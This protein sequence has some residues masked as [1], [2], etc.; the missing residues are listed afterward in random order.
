MDRAELAEAIA[1][2]N[3]P[4]LELVLVQLTGETR[5]LDPPYAPGRTRGLGDNPTGGLPE[6]V[7]QEVRDAAL[8]AI[9]A[10]LDGRPPAIPAPPHELLVRMLGVSMGEPVPDEYGALIAS[11]IEV[12]VGPD[13]V[14]HIDAPEDFEVLI[15]GAGLSGIAT[16]LRLREAGVAFTVVEKNPEVGGTWFE[17]RYPGA[18]VDTPSNLY[19]FSFAPYDW[20]YTFPPRDQLYAYLESLAVPI[21]DRLELETRVHSLTWDDHTKRWVAVTEHAG[22][23]LQRAFAVVVSAVGGLNRLRLPNIPGLDTFGGPVVHTAQWPD[24]LSVAGRRV[25]VIGNGASSMQVTPAV[26]TEVSE[27]TI[28]QRSPQWAAPFDQYQQPVPELLQRLTAAVPLY[29]IWM[30]LRGAWTFNDR[31]YEALHKDPEWPHPERAVSETN[32]GHRRYFTRYI[33]DKLA[34]RP[35]LIAASTPTYP[36]FG[37]RILLDTGWYDTLLMDHVELVTQRIDRIEP[38]AVITED[39]TRRE[40]DVLICATGFDATRYLAP[41]EIRGRSGRT[42]RD[43]WDDDDARAYLGITVPDFPN[44]FIIFGPNSQGG[45]GG[46]F[47]GTAEV[48]IRYILDAL[49]QMTAA[50][51]AAIE[52]KPE[53]YERFAET[54]D[55]KHEQLIWTHQGMDTYYRNSRGRVTVAMPFRVV[56]YWQMARR[57]DMSDFELEPAPNAEVATA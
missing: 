18:A 35:D 20:S 2:A 22:E 51:A 43:T 33:E 42:L 21:R 16:G 29:R 27:L 30:R 5:W 9:A 17:N 1:V 31:N 41:M 15:V 53:V 7:Q 48:Q 38:G 49:A 39:G 50:G 11:E 3:V 34:G 19:S 25:G 26:A 56:D 36:P 8:S 57:A 6:A 10:F 47:V 13:P 37:K 23:R 24:D 46:A 54:V 32:D 52:V 12:A 44:L 4:V 45:H 55:A 40:L 28:F 14:P